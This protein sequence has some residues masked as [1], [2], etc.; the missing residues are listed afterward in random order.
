MESAG[1]NSDG[2]TN[3]TTLYT[4]LFQPLPGVVGNDSNLTLSQWMI[5]KNL[6]DAN[7]MEKA[8]RILAKVVEMEN[9]AFA[10]READL[11][12]FLN[13]LPA[14]AKVIAAALGSKAGTSIQKMIPGETGTASLILAGRGATEGVALLEKIQKSVPEGF[15]MDMLQELL[16][17]PE[18]LARVLR[19]T[20]PSG[21][22]KSL[23][24]GVMTFLIRQGIAT[25]KR[26]LPLIQATGSGA[27]QE[28]SLEEPAP[29][30]E[31]Q[32]AVQAPPQNLMAQRFARPTPTV[33]QPRQQ[34]VAQAP[35]QAPRPPALAQGQA[36]PAQRQRLAQLFPNDPLAQA[37][38]PGGGIGSLF[39]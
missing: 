9:L 25:P 32:A 4:K 29:T 36:N 17:D 21:N 24:D 5:S 1:V 20:K 7:T 16:F 8:R 38:G 14:S 27:L 34:P 13:K 22:Q 28:E 37:A 18:G 11:E 33:I 19:L 23:I 39:S 2:I 3:A 10:G 6:T 15:K 35:A 26:A 30:P 12:G 31:P